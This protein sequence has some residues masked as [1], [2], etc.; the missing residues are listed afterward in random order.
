MPHENVALIRRFYAALHRGEAAEMARCYAPDATFSDPFFHDLRGPEVPGMWDMLLGSAERMSVVADEIE[1]DATT[2]SA[3]WVATYPFS[4]S[5]RDVVND[6]R[7]RFRFRD[8]LI[9]EHVDVFDA[10]RWGVQAI[11]F[12]GNA[13][14]LPPLRG[15][16]ARSLRKELTAHL[17]GDGAADPAS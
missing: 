2:G 1:A 4:K 16:L 10:R 7:A 11:G 17:A 13:L 8:G 9:V 12:K 14:A 3:H 5:G 6:V 15:M